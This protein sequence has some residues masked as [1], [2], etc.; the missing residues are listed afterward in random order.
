VA[1]LLIGSPIWLH[2]ALRTRS[3]DTRTLAVYSAD[4]SGE[5]VRV[6]VPDAAAHDGDREAAGVQKLTS[7]GHPQ[8]RLVGENTRADGTTEQLGE[9]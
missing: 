6:V 3:V 1:L 4:V 5:V 7:M 8:A 9:A 2:S